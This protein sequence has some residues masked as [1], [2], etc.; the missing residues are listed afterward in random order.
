MQIELPAKK[1]NRVIIS[2]ILVSALGYFVDLYD[3]YIFNV[4]RVQSLT[5]LGI[6]Q[7]NLL[8]VGISIMNWTFA[9][10]I[11]GGIFWGVLGDKKGRLKVL[12][13]SIIIYSLATLANAFIQDVTQ[14]K[15]CRLIAGFGL[16][17]ELGAGVTLVC[18]L[19]K[20]AKRGY[21]PVLIAAMGLYGI[22]LGSYISNHFYWRTAYI[23]GSCMG[24][25]L[26]VLRISVSESPL[27][28]KAL[29]SV[30]NRRGNILLIFT[31]RRLFSRY[32][33]LILIGLPMYLIVGIMVTAAPE[34]G[35]KFGMK[36]IPSAATAIA[37]YFICTSTM[38]I[39]SGFMSQL[40][41][42]RKKAI[43]MILFVQL[44][45]VIW[46]LYIPPRSLIGFYAR[47]MFIGTSYWPVLMTTVSEQ[48]GTDLRATATTSIPNFIR[49]L[50]IPVSFL[51]QF[52]VPSL[53]LVNAAGVVA[54]TAIIISIAVVLNIPESFGRHLDY[55]ENQI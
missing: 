26:L 47:C 8:G 33:K 52:L 17:G 12:F 13:G 18:E 37:V 6:T 1:H 40:L 27:F 43:L 41:K 23:I 3:V 7:N 19:M 21:G 54:I 31:R 38:E 32:L 25:V 2:A 16:A 39:F 55:F 24:G 29:E 15:I 53:G 4:V 30:S 20:P 5:S 45:S 22:V 42:S 10:M 51:F 36:E 11:L 46:F 35:R 50:F 28:K 48:F 14:Y 44:V 34:F 49:G 9:G